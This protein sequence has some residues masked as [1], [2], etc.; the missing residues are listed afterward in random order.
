MR[1][2][3]IDG[4]YVICNIIEYG[5]IIWFRISDYTNISMTQNTEYNLFKINN[6]PVKSVIRKVYLKESSGFLFTLS[7][8]GQVTI[9]PFG[10]DITQGTGINVSEVFIS[11]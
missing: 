1:S 9:T 4:K 7:V 8:D 6:T 2:R 10:G 11:K 5:N 3:D